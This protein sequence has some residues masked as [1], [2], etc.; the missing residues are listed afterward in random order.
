MFTRN[1]VIHRNW[2]QNMEYGGFS[3]ENKIFAMI[4][5]REIMRVVWCNS[6]WTKCSTDWKYA[7]KL[8]KWAKTKSKQNEIFWIP[9][10]FEWPRLYVVV[11]VVFIRGVYIVCLRRSHK[12][13]SSVIIHFDFGKS[14]IASAKTKTINENIQRKKMNH[15]IWARKKQTNKKI[16]MKWNLLHYDLCLPK[17]K[18][19]FDWLLSEE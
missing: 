7:N 4:T 6:N 9:N 16:R 2:L 10:S 12:I 8:A 15:K 13:I 3:K 18:F 1:D 14:G 19:T 17:I 11:V 5:E